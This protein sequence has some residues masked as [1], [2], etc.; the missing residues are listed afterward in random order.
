MRPSTSHVTEYR[1]CCLPHQEEWLWRTW[2]HTPHRH[3]FSS[4]LAHLI[5]SLAFQLTAHILQCRMV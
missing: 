1:T 3:H 4:T 2:L 5:M